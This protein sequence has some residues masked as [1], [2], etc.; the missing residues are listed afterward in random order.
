MRQ[1]GGSVLFTPTELRQVLSAYS[2]GVL[3]KGWRDYAIDTVNNQTI[4]S[5]ID[6]VSED[7]DISVYCSISKNKPQK[8]KGNPYYKV[9]L[10]EKPLIK[11][12]SFL[13]ALDVFKRIDDVKKSSKKTSNNAIRLID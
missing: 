10:R 12:E 7:G 4:F 13:E 6:R 8:A 1:T 9:M 2:S 5:V 11:T 3:R